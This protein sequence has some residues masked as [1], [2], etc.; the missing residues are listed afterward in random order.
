MK[1]KFE[2][3]LDGKAFIEFQQS[4]VPWK[5][6]KTEVELVKLVADAA[7]EAYE[8]GKAGLKNPYPDTYQDIVQAYAEMGKAE[9]LDEP[10]FS[11]Y[12]KSFIF[13]THEAYEQGIRA[14]EELNA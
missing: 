7:N 3:P 8:A 9:L 11:H 13:W 1:P 4:G 5:L 14:R 12:F 6:D 10:A 2:Y